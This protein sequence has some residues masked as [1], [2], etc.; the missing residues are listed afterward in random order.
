MKDLLQAKDSLF[1]FPKVGDILEGK[2]VEKGRNRIFVDLG[3]L[4]LALA[5]T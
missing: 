2:V 4:R 5:D 1:V 3:N